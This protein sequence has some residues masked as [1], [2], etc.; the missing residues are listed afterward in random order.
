VKDI[1]AAAYNP[2][3]GAVKNEKL[4][5]LLTRYGI[6]VTVNPQTPAK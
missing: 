1:A 4:K 2:T 5:D 6:N 3:T